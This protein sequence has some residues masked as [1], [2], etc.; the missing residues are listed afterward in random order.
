[1]LYTPMIL[2]GRQEYKIPPQFVNVVEDARIERLMK[3]SLSWFG[4][5]FFQR[6]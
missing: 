2:T 6:I 4:E 1:M 3:R 5:D